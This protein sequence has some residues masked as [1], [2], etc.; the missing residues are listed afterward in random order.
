V[1]PLVYVGTLMTENVFYPVFAWFALALVAALDRPTLRRQ[2]V[3]LALC[4]LAFLTRAQ[5]IVLVAVALTAPLVLAWIER[6]RP[7]RLGAWKPLYGLVA[8]AV[9]GIVVGEVAVGNSPTH[10]LGGYSVAGHTSYQVW[11][12]LQWVL[13]HLAAVDL[14]LWI[15]PAAALVVVGAS[16]RHLDRPLRVFAAATAT[17][18]AWLVLEVGVFAS[19]FSLRLEERNLFYLAPLLVVA[20]LAWIERGQPRPP[21]AVVA[22]ALVAAALPAAIPFAKLLNPNSETD[23]PFLQTWWWM[24]RNTVTLAVV[25]ASIVLA[26]L[27]LW[28]SPRFA[29]WLP[30]LVAVGFLV[31][32]LPLQLSAHSFPRLSAAAL[33]AGTPADRTWIDDVVGP[34][35]NVAVL[36]S[37]G[38][39][40]F[41]V[42]ENDFWN[43]SVR[44]VYGLNGA[45]LPG[46]IAQTTV[47][48]DPATGA[49]QPAPDAQYV[50]ADSSVQLLGR[51]VAADPKHNLVLYAV[52]QPVRLTTRITG[53]YPPPDNWTGPQTT[54]TRAQCRGGTLR[55]TIYGDPNLFTGV[56]Q[57][58]R[59]SGTTPTQTITVPGPDAPLT[60]R[61]PLT[62]RGGTCTVRLD[63]SPVRKPK[64]DPRTLGVHAVGF[65][66]VP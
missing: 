27:F 45:T 11:P 34:Q 39:N 49:L 38:D 66:Y 26:A 15:L 54:W 2:V 18:T 19:R 4:A 32:W 52:R 62:P 33:H 13:Y 44:R 40:P 30:A 29:G 58:V 51:R 22:A 55:V 17:L 56:T 53:W 25:A 8:L 43:R 23:T 57:H 36:W 7:R 37:G 31:T 65:T 14:S 12:M 50:L 9:V 64:G 20:L 48:A 46:G 10:V 63:P 60:L 41:R 3:L 61:L 24:S 35:A 47:R 16:A 59:I 6:G 5:A 1:P 28:L 42:W 21:R